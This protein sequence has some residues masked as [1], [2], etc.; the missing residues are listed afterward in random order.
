MS[1]PL[2]TFSTAETFTLFNEIFVRGYEQKVEILVTMIRIMDKEKV[3]TGL[4]KAY[5]FTC[6][7]MIW[8]TPLIS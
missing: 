5:T 3:H 8:K 7:L 4:K 1:L 6:H 2:P